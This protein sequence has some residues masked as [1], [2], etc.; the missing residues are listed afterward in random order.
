MV[1]RHYIHSKFLQYIWQ[2]K[3]ERLVSLFVPCED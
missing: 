3:N 1:A 2:R